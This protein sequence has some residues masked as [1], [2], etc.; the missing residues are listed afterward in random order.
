MRDQYSPGTSGLMG[1]LVDRERHPFLTLTFAVVGSILFGT[2]FV[3]LLVGLQADAA[4]AKHD[5]NAEE[6]D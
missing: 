5:R 1:S 6:E 2:T 3:L 4:Q